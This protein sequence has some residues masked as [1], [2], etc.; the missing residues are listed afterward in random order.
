MMP[1]SGGLRSQP[2]KVFHSSAK[3]GSKGSLHSLK[4]N[5]IVGSHLDQLVTSVNKKN[6]KSTLQEINQVI[7]NNFFFVSLRDAV[8]DEILA[9]G[10][11]ILSLD[12]V[13]NEFLLADCNVW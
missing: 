10:M 8:V 11:Q 5:I 3:F 7:L 1:Q 6:L 12:W 9:R 4:F 13:I 2:T